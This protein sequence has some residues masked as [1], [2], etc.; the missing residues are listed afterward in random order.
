MSPTLWHRASGTLDSWDEKFM[1]K[2]LHPSNLS[3]SGSD[4]QHN[5]HPWWKTK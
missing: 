4:R 5:I 3:S 1:W 2:E